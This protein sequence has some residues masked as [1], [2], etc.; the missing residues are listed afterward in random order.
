MNEFWHNEDA[1]QGVRFKGIVDAL[2]VNATEPNSSHISIS[3][4]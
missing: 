2:M 3:S 1:E 4:F